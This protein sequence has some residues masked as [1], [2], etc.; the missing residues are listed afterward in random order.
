MLLT[1]YFIGIVLCLLIGCQSSKPDPKM[2]RA[3]ELHKEA[4][5]IY[6]AL[7]DALDKLDPQSMTPENQQLL[8]TIKEASD[9]WHDNLVEVPG[10]EHE[11][12]H[13]HDHDHDHGDDALKDLPPGEMLELQQAIL[14][15]VQRLLKETRQL[16]NGN[17]SS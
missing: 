16:A 1:R 12:G 8:G 4:L 11:E 13:D 10:F 7:T 15:E 9:Q 6:D 17:T 14:D 3:F 5:Q 2:A